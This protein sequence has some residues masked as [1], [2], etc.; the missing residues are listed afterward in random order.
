[1]NRF[2]SHLARCAAAATLALGGLAFAL[3]ANADVPGAHPGYLHGLD[4]LRA[5]Y[6][7]LH[8][9][10][11]GNVERE[12]AAAL[13]ELDAAFRDARRA[14]AYD[15]KNLADHPPVD[16]NVYGRR[17][18]DAALVALQDAHAQFTQYESNGPDRG[19]QHRTVV[20]VDAAIA[21]VKRAMADRRYDGNHGF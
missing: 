19:W 17:R 14:A 1:M 13:R 3:P 7:A 16:A 10:A 5:A 15:G 11:P 12:Q 20:H 9:D 4:D 18:L 8:H 6:V 2:V 21:H